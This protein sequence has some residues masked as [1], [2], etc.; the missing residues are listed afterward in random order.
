MRQIKNIQEAKKY[1]NKIVYFVDTDKIKPTKLYIGGVNLFFN[2]VDYDVLGFAVFTG[3][4]F[5]ELWGNIKVDDIKEKFEE[6]NHGLVL[7][8][9]L[10][11]AQQYLNYLKVDEKE[12][13]KRN[14]I[15]EA[16]RLLDEHKVNY[17]IF[18]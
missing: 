12:T 8:F 14:A 11:L 18:E 7:V 10:E 16:K 5:S 13:D 1:L 2:Q 15:K 17:E 3:K 6:D 4:E 9:S